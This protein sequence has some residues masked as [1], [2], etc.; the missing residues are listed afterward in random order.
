MENRILILGSGGLIG[1]KTLDRFQHDI[2]PQFLITGHK[3]DLSDI[4]KS[5]ERVFDLEPTLIIQ[6]AWSASSTPDYRHDAAN[7]VWAEFTKLL[8]FSCV[9][10]NIDFIG[11]GSGV[12]IDSSNNDSY[13]AGK[14]LAFKAI[15][16]LVSREL[17]TWARLGYVFDPVSKSPAVLREILDALDNA[18]HANVK[19]PNSAH[20]FIHVDDVADALYRIAV[21][22]KKGLFEIGNERKHLV[23]D[24]AEALGYIDTT[25]GDIKPSR[26]SFQMNIS[27]LKELGWNANATKQF[28]EEA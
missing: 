15:E 13:T 27:R 11:I 3:L 4:K 8:A 5:I 9:S 1:R 21:S 10:K 14:K 6:L 7:F 23:R 16:Q 22:G 28:F 17:I 20:D 2:S 25:W 19:E 18:R 26:E 24:V 12:E